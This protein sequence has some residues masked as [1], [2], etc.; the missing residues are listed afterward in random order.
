MTTHRTGR[1]QSP[2]AAGP[3]TLDQETTLN[4]DPQTTA[5]PERDEA[6]YIDWHYEQFGCAPTTGQGPAPQNG[7]D[8]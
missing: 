3:T 2:R 5:R 4:D 6:A 1:P 7:D 8:A